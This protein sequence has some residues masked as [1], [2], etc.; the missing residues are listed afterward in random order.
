MLG[1]GVREIQLQELKKQVVDLTI[2]LTEVEAELAKPRL[3]A[4][5]AEY[6]E[7]GGEE[8][9]ALHL[10]KI[11]RKYFS[12]FSYSGS[13]DFVPPMTEVEFIANILTPQKAL[14]AETHE[15]KRSRKGGKK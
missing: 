6:E 3:L 12:P 14:W 5:I 8:E 10:G 2:R 4:L 15:C 1:F 9:Y 11:A 7:W 13:Y